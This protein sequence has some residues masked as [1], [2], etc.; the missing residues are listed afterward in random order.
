MLPNYPLVI[1]PRY[2]FCESLS[3]AYPVA[4][5][6][7]MTASLSCQ[8]NCDN[9]GQTQSWYLIMNNATQGWNFST[10]VSYTS[11]FLSAEWIEE[12]PSSSA[13]TLPLADF[14][15]V[16]FHPTV[17]AGSLPSLT[18]SD[19]IVMANPYGETSSPSSP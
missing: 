14:A 19:A 16:T 12:A 5:G 11:T 3:C 9:P 7:R 15:T 13:G 17:D 18:A 4:P 2:P 1:S 10:A 8:T 6:D